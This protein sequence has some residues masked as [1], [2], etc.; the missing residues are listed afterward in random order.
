M[1]NSENNKKKN[2]TSNISVEWGEENPQT[3][4]TPLT[5][6]IT[7]KLGNVQDPSFTW[8]FSTREMQTFMETANSSQFP[9]PY[10]GDRH[11]T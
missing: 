6:L 5:K 10:P 1:S 7:W 9:L 2:I 3:L 8:T 4:A 11:L